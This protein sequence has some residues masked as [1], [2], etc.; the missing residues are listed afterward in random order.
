[1]R[2]CIQSSY[3]NKMNSSTKSIITQAALEGGLSAAAM[4][5]ATPMLISDEVLAVATPLGV[6]SLPMASALAVGGA[7]AAVD[8]MQLVAPESHKKMA[9][10]LSGY[11]KLAAASAASI[12]ISYFLFGGAM[13]GITNYAKFAGA[14]AICALVGDRA[15]DLIRDS[16]VFAY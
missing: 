3:V 9:A 14:S 11:G 8:L 4:Y 16:K 5:V 1:M 2:T 15:E 12:G 7:V 6:L 13:A 10:S